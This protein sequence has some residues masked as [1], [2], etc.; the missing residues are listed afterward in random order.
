[1]AIWAAAI[2]A[3]ASLIGAGMQ[4]AGQMNTNQK[5]EDLANQN[6][7]W[8]ANMANTA[9][10]RQFTDMRAAGINPILAMGNGADTPSA[11]AIAMQNPMNDMSSSMG[12]AA[13]SAMQA[14]RLK[15]EMNESDARINLSNEQKKLT[16]A[17]TLAT[18]AGAAKTL[19]ETPEAQVKSRGWETADQAIKNFRGIVN[20]IIKNSAKEHKP[21]TFN[22]R[23]TGGINIKKKP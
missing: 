7:A 17:Q 8:T 6:N 14:V 13:A 12:G 20:G 3:V 1:M 18:Q 23:G 22:W 21:R 2:P 10:Q 19:A 4:H 11:Q 15:Q 5:S 9:Y 16:G